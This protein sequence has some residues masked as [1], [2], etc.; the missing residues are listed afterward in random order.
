MEAVCRHLA[1]LLEVAVIQESPSPFS[2][3]IV[4][5]RKENNDIRLCIVQDSG[6]DGCLGVSLSATLCYFV[7]VLC[8]LLPIA[9]HLKTMTV[10][11]RFWLEQQWL[12][13]GS[14]EDGY[15][16]N[17]QVFSSS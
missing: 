14:A 15:A 8:F 9:C 4:M 10:F 1:E 17:V 2:S 16:V 7:C 6:V 3:S 12:S 5:L 11:L 13:I